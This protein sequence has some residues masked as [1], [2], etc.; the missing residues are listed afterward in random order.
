MEQRLGQSHLRGA[1][2]GIFLLSVLSVSL[3][4]STT[5]SR[6][7]SA[8]GF[9]Y[10]TLR[11]TVGLL[12]GTDCRTAPTPQTSPEPTPTPVQPAQPLQANQS[13]APSATAPQPESQ[14]VEMPTIQTTPID[15]TVAALEPI[16]T[17]PNATHRLP[18]Q[19]TNND[20]AAYIYLSTGSVKG[21]ATIAT[22]PIEKSGEGW[23]IL[24]VAWY[25]WV[26][27]LVTLVTLFVWGK[28]Q[29]FKN[30]FSIARNKQ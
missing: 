2:I 30:L 25:W 28:K 5:Y 9:L 24:T 4:V 3:L 11:C 27:G 22:A 10:S 16:T 8:E 19:L 14:S 26:L 20:Y 13:E 18:V 21:A 29:N 17:L 15:T 7:A 6:P 12:T 1:K 23:R